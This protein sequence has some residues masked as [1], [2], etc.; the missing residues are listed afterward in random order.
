MILIDYHV[1][2]YKYSSMPDRGVLL[3]CKANH[4]ESLKMAL[5]RCRRSWVQLYTWWTTA[6]RVDDEDIQAGGI[7]M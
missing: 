3:Y 7:D 4:H 5:Y 1:G 6:Y 2:I